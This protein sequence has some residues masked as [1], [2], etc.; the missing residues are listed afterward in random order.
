MTEFYK[1]QNVGKYNF[2]K[3]C[4][5]ISGVTRVLSRE[6]TILG[7]QSAPDKNKRK[8]DHWREWEIILIN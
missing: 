5:V 7:E 4:S 8:I 2:L 6:K 3:N 1:L